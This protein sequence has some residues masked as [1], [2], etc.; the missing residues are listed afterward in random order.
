MNRSERFRIYLFTLTILWN[1]SV[2]AQLVN[3]L[4][5]YRSYVPAGMQV[6]YSSDV[7]GNGSLIHYESDNGRKYMQ[8]LEL[9]D[10]SFE[11]NYFDNSGKISYSERLVFDAHAN[12]LLQGRNTGDISI[13]T[14]YYPNGKI[15]RYI[16]SKEHPDNINRPII[17]FKYTEDSYHIR[18]S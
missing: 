4:V 17:E 3:G 10:G 12:L 16:Y 18:K 13:G 9:P 5:D 11:I 8:R 2:K 7:P 15:S 1:W 6:N 14:W